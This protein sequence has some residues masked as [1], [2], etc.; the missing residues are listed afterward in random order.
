MKKILLLSFAFAALLVGQFSTASAQPCTVDNQYTSPGIYPSDTLQDMQVG[1]AT[2]QVIQFVFPVDTV[3]FGFTLPFDSF[4]VS[5]V[6][7]IPP[8]INWQCNQNHP[9]C[10]YVSNPPNLTRGCVLMDG[11]PLAASPAYPGYDSIIVTGTAYVN[12]PFVGVTPVAQDIPVFYRVAGSAAASSPFANAGLQI[13]PNPVAATAN[14]RYFLTAD[15]DVK[16]TVM[17]L[18]GR[19]IAVIHSGIQRQGEQE[20]VLDS[21]NIAT[22]AYL[23]KLNIN[24]GEFIQ[25]R[26]FS[27]VR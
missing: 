16:V 26:K 21:K 27:S 2:S 20:V 10:L 3:I 24:N 18:M 5:N 13:A 12:V 4:K 8:G 6:S 7:A 9:T 22:G 11:T 1:A 25:T 15:A 14:V 19:E 17:D 23:L